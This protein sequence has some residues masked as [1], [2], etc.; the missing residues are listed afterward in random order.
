[1]DR[2]ICVTQSFDTTFYYGIKYSSALFWDYPFSE[3]LSYIKEVIHR[4]D[5]LF[6]YG[7]KIIF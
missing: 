2:P 1:M 3:L 4:H 6:T 7:Y 5:R